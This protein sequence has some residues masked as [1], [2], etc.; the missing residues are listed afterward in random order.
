MKVVRISLQR[1]KHEFTFYNQSC[2]YAVKRPVTTTRCVFKRWSQKQQLWLGCQRCCQETQSDS[3]HK[4]RVYFTWIFNE[5]IILQWGISLEMSGN[6]CVVSES[7][8]LNSE[9]SKKIVKF[10]RYIVILVFYGCPTEINCSQC[11]ALWHSR[12]KGV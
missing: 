9:K 8:I 4:K 2:K 12:T 5:F 6:H 3:C 7:A 10:C 1:P 11:T